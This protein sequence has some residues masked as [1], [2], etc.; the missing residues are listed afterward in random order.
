MPIPEAQAGADQSFAYSASP[1]T[2]TLAGAATNTPIT[3]WEWTMLSVPSGSSADSGANQDFTDGVSTLQNPDFNMDVPGC[4]VLQLKAQN[5]TGWSKPD[6]DLE[7]G[8]TLCFMRTQKYDL[9]IPGYKAYRYDPYLNGSVLDLETGLADHSSRHDP[10][11]VDAVTTAAPG[12]TGVATASGEGSAA[13]FARSD[14][15]H[16]SNTAPADVTKAAAAIGTSGEPARADHK[17]NVT[18]AAPAAAGV[19]TASGEGTATTLARSDHSH[20]SNTAPADVTKAAAVVGTSGEPA[21]ADH[22]HDV[23]TAVAGAATPGDSATEGAATSLARSDHQHSLPAFGTGAGT[24]CEGND[25]RLSDART[26]TAHD[27]GGAE[28]TAD[29]L[30]DLN[31]KVTDYSLGNPVTAQSSTPLTLTSSDSGKL[32]TNEG[33][34][35]QI[36]FNLPTAA[37]GLE[38]SFVIQDADG[39]QV[40]AASGDTI[41]VAGS[42]S[43]AAG[44]IAATTIG[45][46]V[47]LK[48]INATEWIA[49]SYVGTWTVT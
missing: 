27:L 46:T 22:K 30:A 38:F 45:N 10:G 44:N 23:S 15:S 47:H 4:Y 42:V 29:A 2:V 1:V 14:H 25:S 49:V 12:A 11:G 31:G 33:A 32:Y 17:H 21:R 24:F 28:H 7:G 8:Q 6:S 26:P 3:A 39:I 36:V 9:E 43:A 5:A 20:Q 13:S 34:A 41:R 48:A 35:A 16:Q 37:A 40:V 18:T 19:G